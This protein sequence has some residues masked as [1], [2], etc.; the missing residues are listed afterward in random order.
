MNKALSYVAIA[1]LLGTVTMLAPLILIK[2]TSSLDSNDGEDVPMNLP[3]YMCPDEEK[4]GLGVVNETL[5]RT[6]AFERTLR[7]SNLSSAGLILIP[8][9]LLALGISLYLKKRTF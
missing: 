9:F 1:I 7:L 8:S 2:P 3:K 6:E 5:E 4:L